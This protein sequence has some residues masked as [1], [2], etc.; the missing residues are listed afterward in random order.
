MIN[1]LNEGVVVATFM[2]GV[3]S[4]YCLMTLAKM[5]PKTMLELLEEVNKHIGVEEILQG[6]N[7]SGMSALLPSSN[8]LG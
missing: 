2:E 3:N 8:R 4:P 5:A 6:R 1:N 7:M